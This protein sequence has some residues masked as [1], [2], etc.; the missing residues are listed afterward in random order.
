MQSTYTAKRLRWAGVAITSTA[1]LLAGCSAGAATDAETDGAIGSLSLKFTSYASP[2]APISQALQQSFDALAES[3]DGAIEVE[4]FWSASLLSAPDGL[5]GAADGR[6]DI[7]LITAAYTPSEMP[8][9]QLLGVPF[10]APSSASVSLA[11]KELY[12][13]SPAF[14]NEFSS[15]GVHLLAVI[16]PGENII[17]TTDPIEGPEDLEGLQ[18]R[19]AGYIANAVQ[20]WDAN[21][22]ALPATDMYES[23]ERGLIDGYTSF[24]YELIA[25]FGLNEVATNITD[26]GT[27]PYIASYIVINKSQ[28]DGFSDAQRDAITASYENVA[29]WSTEATLEIEAATCDTLLEN[30][31]S[32]TVW[33]E[34]KVKQFRDKIGDSLLKEWKA[35]AS[36]TGVDPDAFYDELQTA[37]DD[38]GD[39]ERQTGLQE[40]ASR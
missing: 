13:T 40:C 6:A 9:S 26:P 15:N 7:S 31:G 5:A 16:A 39:Q 38:V 2:T 17:A 32:V 23:I 30:G 27:G 37:L 19:A 28:W 36:A 14:Q 4:P 24:A 12:D 35:T 10:V 33:D 8:L 3:T 29:D 1:L 20:E 25:S 21:V 34:T 22:Q 11:L 18:L